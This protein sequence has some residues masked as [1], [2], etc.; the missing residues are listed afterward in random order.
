M[1]TWLAVIALLPGL[2]SAQQHLLAAAELIDVTGPASGHAQTLAWIH[3]T[4]NRGVFVAGAARFELDDTRWTLGR[5]EYSHP[6]SERLRA[7]AALEAG[8][9]RSGGDRFTYRKLR[10]GVE[11]ELTPALALTVGDT[12]VNIEPS[13]GHLLNA[14]LSLRATPRLYLR[15]GLH[16]ALG[17]RLDASAL[18]VRLDHH[19]RVHFFAG[20]VDGR[21]SDPRLLN[22]AGAP[23]GAGDY[24]QAYFGVDLPLR[25][26]TLSVT[27]DLIDADAARRRAFGVALKLPLGRGSSPR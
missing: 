26:A 13:V 6:L 15:I 7:S 17:S 1:R 22:L 18:A 19:G 24:R 25:A 12:Y 5:M 16:E 23:T 27:L 21:T 2:S 20:A 8:P 4:P 3:T 9:A 11:F 10:L 14:D